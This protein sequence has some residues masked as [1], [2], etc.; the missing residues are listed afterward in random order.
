MI[1]KCNPIVDF[2]DEYLPY[3]IEISFCYDKYV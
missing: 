2:V 1:S 3:T